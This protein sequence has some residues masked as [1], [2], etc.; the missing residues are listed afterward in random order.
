MGQ[1]AAGKPAREALLGGRQRRRAKPVAVKA[2]REILRLPAVDQQQGGDHP[3]ARL[4]HHLA[5]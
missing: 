2:G 5:F 4:R 3:A 1:G